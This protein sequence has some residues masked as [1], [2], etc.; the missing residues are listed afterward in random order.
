MAVHSLF[1]NCSSF[2]SVKLILLLE[3]HIMANPFVIESEKC[4]ADLFSSVHTH[5]TSSPKPPIGDFRAES[6]NL[7]ALLHRR[8]LTVYKYI[9]DRGGH[10]LAKQYSRC[11]TD[12]WVVQHEQTLELRVASRKCNQRWCPMCQKTK[13]WIITNSVKE[14]ASRQKHLKFVTFTLKSSDASVELQTERLY[15]SFKALRRTS[16][17][18]NKVRGG[19]WFFQMTVNKSTGLWHPHIHVLVDADYIPKRLLKCAWKKITFDSHI[20]DIKKVDN[21]EKAS[22]Y[23]ARY[24]TIPADLLKCSVSQGAALVI[25]LKGTRMCGCFGTAKGLALRPKPLDEPYT[26]R[27]VMS[28]FCMAVGS[29]LD[30]FIEMVERSLATGKPFEGEIWGLYDMPEMPKEA[31][32]FEPETNRQIMLNFDECFYVTGRC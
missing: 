11:R 24:A 31:V 4:E 6:V 20:V 14:W 22:E 9:H 1:L 10:N 23:V 17:F 27:K 3:G 12:A 32:E 5:S 18:K 13:R 25:G 30:P 16:F 29:K 26:W 15:D 19:V 7:V 8:L 28:Y 2:L 21:P